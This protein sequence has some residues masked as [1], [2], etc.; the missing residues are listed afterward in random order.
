MIGVLDRRINMVNRLAAIFLFFWKVTVT[1]LRSVRLLSKRYYAKFQYN[2]SIFN[3]ASSPLKF[4]MLYLEL[5]IPLQLENRN[6]TA[7]IERLCNYCC[8]CY[9]SISQTVYILR[10]W[11]RRPC[12]WIALPTGLL[13]RLVWAPALRSGPT[14]LSS[15]HAR[16]SIPARRFWVAVPPEGKLGQ[17]LRLISDSVERHY[18]HV[19]AKN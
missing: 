19:H 9:C 8:F 14:S 12:L 10:V 13:S 17:W 1:P 6:V 15:W 2:R 7:Y 18:K 11:S 4:V 3:A 16:Q 5:S